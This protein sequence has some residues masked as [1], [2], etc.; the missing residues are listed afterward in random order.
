[1]GVNPHRSKRIAGVIIGIA[2]I[3][4][5]AAAAALFFVMT[6]P[7]Q[8]QWH[9]ANRGEV[10]VF[11]D[12]GQVSILRL[13]SSQSEAFDY[14]RLNSRGSLSIDDAPYE[15]TSDKQRMDID[16]LGVY[17]KADDQ[18]DSDS[19]LNQYGKLG[20][21]YSEERGEVLVFSPAGEVQRIRLSGADDAS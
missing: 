19:F 2:V 6:S 8:G 13:V 14:D 4:I 7:V 16:G 5:A 21:W 20:T 9:N 17:T 18:F 11:G 1:M 12:D 10:L 15:F 3:L